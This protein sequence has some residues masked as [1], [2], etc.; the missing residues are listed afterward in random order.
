MYVLPD[1]LVLKAFGQ[2]VATLDVMTETWDI[3]MNT[4]VEF[5]DDQGSG[6]MYRP[7]KLLVIGGDQDNLTRP[8]SSYHSLR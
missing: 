8:Q 3:V 5:R 1:G 2:E 4:P 6:V 7:G